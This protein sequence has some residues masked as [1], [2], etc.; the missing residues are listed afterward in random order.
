MQKRKL[1]AA[2]CLCLV[3]SVPLS[4]S[5][6]DFFVYPTKNQSAEQQ[7]RDKSECRS[8]AT[9]QSGFD[10]A[11]RPT[12]STPPP[13]K[14]APKGGL[15]Q[16]AARGVALGAVGG[17]IGGNAGKGAAMGAALGGMGGVM[18]RNDQVREERYAHDQWASEN[19]A[20]YEQKRSNWTRAV[21]ACLTG[22]GY[23]VQ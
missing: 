12:A 2:I 13:R 3:G 22:R 11:Q 6:G 9:Q 15:V 7:E 21:N 1:I 17:A 16:G 19:T 14:Q 5:A 4:T 10:P 23:T 18:R 8:W 20:L